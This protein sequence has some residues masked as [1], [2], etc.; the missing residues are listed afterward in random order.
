MTAAE[1]SGR[2]DKGVLHTYMAMD[3]PDDRVMAEYIW[4]DGTGQG[5]R[6]KCRTLD[7]EPKDPKGNVTVENK[8]CI[9]VKIEDHVFAL[10][11]TTENDECRPKYNEVKMF[12]LHFATLKFTLP[13]K[14]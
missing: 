14:Y 2:L 11:S 12:A 4:I 1:Y 9:F 5:L 8:P 7:F 10:G 13:L 6:S 3:Q